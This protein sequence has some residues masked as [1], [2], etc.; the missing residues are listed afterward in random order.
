M[1]SS[2]LSLTS[3]LD[4]GGWST[5]RSG[6]FTPRNDPV[7]IVQEAGLELG[8]D[9]FLSQAFVSYY[10]LPSNH[11]KLL[12][13]LLT[14]SLITVRA[15]PC[16]GRS[17]EIMAKRNIGVQRVADKEADTVHITHIISQ[18]SCIAKLL[19]SVKCDYCFSLMY[20]LSLVDCG[21]KK[22]VT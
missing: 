10:S 15:K 12:S 6:R 19:I 7:S 13:D 1:Y 20:S 21:Q 2:T 17:S 4:G 14:A 3:A 8:R 9:R 22:K 18:R 16:V 11:L 5:S